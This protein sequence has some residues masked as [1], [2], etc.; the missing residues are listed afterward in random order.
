MATIKDIAERASVSVAT[1]SRVLNNDATM[2][3]SAETRQK[4]FET[5]DSL[6]Y[7][8][9]KRN[10]ASSKFKKR[11]AVIQWYT[12]QEE[13]QDL[14]YYS[15]RVGI[16][17][18]A[19]TLGYDIVRI[20]NDTPLSN[21]KN[22]DGIVAVGKYS[23]TQIKELEKLSPNL[24]FVDSDTLNYG[25]TCITTD[26]ENS[27]INA[28]DHFITNKQY[29]IGM[30]AGEEFTADKKT[31]LIDPRFYTF[32]N[33][34]SAQRLYNSKYVY[35]GKFTTDDGYTLMKQAIVDHKDNLPQAFFIANDA[36]A[37]GALRA[38]HEANIKVPEQVSII[39]FNDT[40][41]AR[42]VYPPLSSITVFTEEMGKTAISTLCNILNNNTINIPIMI[43]LSTKLNLRSSS[44]NN[45]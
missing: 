4:I 11:I 10:S 18:Q 41:I 9:Y 29:R 7:I 34:L 45:T 13:S 27:V 16:E 28:L 6:G 12:E 37:I 24:I 32:K 26:F 17:E 42:Q 22:I 33:Y 35:I 3:V 44:I 20:F 21:A 23:Y 31:P 15:I 43:K 38:L 5:A 2:S 25:H 1:V 30:L 14:Y 19:L 8:K 39:S 40:A 36:L